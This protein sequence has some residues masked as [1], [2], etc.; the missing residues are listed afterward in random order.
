MKKFLFFP[1][2]ICCSFFVKAQ[3]QGDPRFPDAAQFT[4]SV[5]THKL[6][7]SANKTFGYDIYSDGK[8]MIHQPCIPSVPGNEGFRSKPEAER[9]AR[10]VMGKIKKGE[11]PPSVTPEELKEL[12]I[13][14]KIN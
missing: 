13:T 5:I 14:L 6:I 4:R 7:A 12:N 2:F 11:M 10:L 3:Q 8:L 9:A 1:L